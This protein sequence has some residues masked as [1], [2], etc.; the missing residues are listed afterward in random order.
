M[1][2]SD[3][4]SDVCSSDLDYVLPTVSLIRG[5]KFVRQLHAIFGDER[6]EALRRPYFC[7]T[8]NLTKGCS[9]THDRG[10]LHLWIATSMAVPGVAPPLVFEGE[11]HADGAVA[12]SLPTDVMQAL[13]RGPIVAS[14]VSRERKSTRLKL[15]SLMRTSYAVFC[16]KT[17]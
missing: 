3:W 10:P 9:A 17:K 2:I 6:I 7:V 1:R 13:D 12:N 5:R 14:N 16:L 11:L 15:Q 4:S 8:T